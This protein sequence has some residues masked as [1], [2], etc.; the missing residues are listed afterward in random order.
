MTYTPQPSTADLAHRLGANAHACAVVAS[1]ALSANLHEVVLAGNARELAGAPGQDVMVR[2]EGAD[3]R[4]VRRRY[5]VR[6]LDDAADQL[7][8][9][10]STNHDGPGA[11]WARRVIAG[12]H[13]DVIGPRGKILLDPVADWHLFLGDL[14]SMAESFRLADAIEPPGQALFLFEVDDP[15]DAQTPT[16]AEG[17]GV[18]GV[19][20]ERA[21]R[22]GDDATGLLRALAALDLPEGLGH[23]YVLGEF[24]VVRD[25]QVA[26]ADRGLAPEQV[27]AKSFWRAGRANADHGEPEKGE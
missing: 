3:G 4:F 14:S 24:H 11:E 25:L 15:S 21:G 23:A 20:V 12:D 13:V 17:L 2:V 27:S 6:H 8:I 9:W 10:I 19:F 22:R 7:S 1:R 18:T 5:S 26:L 16:M